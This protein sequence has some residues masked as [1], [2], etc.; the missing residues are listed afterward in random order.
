MKE[1]ITSTK[2]LDGAESINI[3]IAMSPATLSG[4]DP[5]LS[6]G[7]RTIGSRKHETLAAIH[8]HRKNVLASLFM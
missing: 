2:R 6:T 3:P 5:L 7:K 8:A 4:Q 1:R